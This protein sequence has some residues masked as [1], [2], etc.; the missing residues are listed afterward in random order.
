M[1][2]FLVNVGYSDGTWQSCR[3]EV[4]IDDTAFC[5]GIADVLHG[6]VCMKEWQQFLPESARNRPIQF[7]NVSYFL[8]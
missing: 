6:R 1:A 8:S 4:D 2:L 7:V 5:D 3:A